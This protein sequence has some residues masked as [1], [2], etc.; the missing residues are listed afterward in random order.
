MHTDAM[1]VLYRQYYFPLYI[2]AL[3]LCKHKET[4]E[5]LVS[6]S[7]EKAF[8]MEELEGM[9]VKYWLITVCRNLWI[10]KQRKRNRAHQ[11]L[12]FFS[13]S[14]GEGEPL[15]QVIQNERF[16]RLY[17]QIG[18]LPRHYQEVLVL[19]YFTGASLAE[20]SKITGTSYANVKVLIFRARIKLKKFLEEDSY[21]F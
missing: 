6:A 10:D 11:L 21:E 9:K 13:F 20:I 12:S 14:E 17:V 2:Y 19:H 8:C 18:K 4:A 5:D 3:S 16:Q 1:E 7:F 15:E